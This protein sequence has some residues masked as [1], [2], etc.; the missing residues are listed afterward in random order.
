[1]I[2]AELHDAFHGC[3]RAELD[4]ADPAAAL[5]RLRVGAERWQDSTE[6]L[7]LRIEALRALG[8]DHEVEPLLVAWSAKFGT[9][10]DYLLLAPPA[11][12]AGGA[13]RA[14]DPVVRPRQLPAVSKDLIGRQAEVD[15]LAESLRGHGPAAGRITVVTGPAG[16]GKTS[17]AVTAAK[18]VEEDAFP[19]GTL[20]IDLRGFSPGQPVDVAAALVRFLNDLQ[21]PCDTPT[22]EG[23][24]TAYRSALAE[25]RVLV[26]LDNARDEAQ[27]RP[28][29]PGPGRSAAL[30]TSRQRLDG[31]VVKESA[32]QVHLG[33]LG[34]VDALELLVAL[35]E[36][37]RIDRAT[38]V[39]ED[40]LDCCAGLP[41]ALRIV[42]AQVT[43]RSP[44]MLA[45]T[46]RT[47]RDGR[48][49]LGAMD[50]RRDGLSVPSLLEGSYRLLNR[51][52][53]RLLWQLAVHPGPTISW[54]AIK[55]MGRNAEGPGGISDAV[56]ELVGMNLVDDTEDGRYVLHDLIRLYGTG[57][58][59]QQ[60]PAERLDTLTG[61]M[62]FLLH[63]AHACDRQ[64]DPDRRLPIAA[65]PDVWTPSPT[66]PVEAM[67][68][69]DT[70]YPTLTGMFE[71]A[72]RLGQD[73][74][75]W[76]LALAVL[77][78]QWRSNRYLDAAE[79]LGAALEAAE[80]VAAPT[81]VALVRRLLAGT[82][83]NLGRPEEAV[84][85]LRQAVRTSE[86]AGDLTGFAY[87]CHSLGVLL[88]ESGDADQALVQLRGALRAFGELD[89]DLGRGTVLDALAHA[90][91]LR[92]DRAEALEHGRRS[93]DML[94]GTEDR[95]GLA[96]AWFT[97]GRIEAAADRHEAA[98]DAYRQAAGTYREIG[99]SSRTARVLVRLADSLERLGDADGQREALAEARTVLTGLGEPD[100]DAAVRRQRELT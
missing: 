37:A 58:A 21:A 46:V 38:P 15:R 94:T 62:N 45:D 88:N 14:A 76:H 8:R 4:C 53:R 3:V 27:V 60:D 67:A 56:D 44:A 72:R 57:L 75:V 82:H 52:A 23:M 2:L 96:H 29:L 6:L 25:R 97:L 89:D 71:L 59:E 55:A 19:D 33:T 16:V 28:L 98:V 86:Q 11:A 78:Y 31:L 54:E 18:R 99:Y 63:N 36:P 49:R 42:A 26:V 51:P 35:T 48:T 39:V 74:Y 64:L 47:L 50:L 81:D 100:L 9:A 30:V 90:H 10:A 1:M 85:H 12:R 87:G 7:S 17:T 43:R 91:H 13:G 73:R 34:R 20:Y 68:W 95:N 32:E 65:D 61:A 41:M 66:G 83:R 5:A 77:T 92:G 69:F 80:R 84:R 24:G 40:L 22:S 70:E 79:H 93:V